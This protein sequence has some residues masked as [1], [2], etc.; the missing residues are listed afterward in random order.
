MH[1]ICSCSTDAT[2]VGLARYGQGAGPIV[3]DDVRCTGSEP[4]ILNC[5]YDVN[6]ADCTHAEDAGVQ[7]SD[8]KFSHQQELLEH[9]SHMHAGRVYPCI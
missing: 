2:A 3:L 1:H 9:T 4:N 5:P 7:C 6:T 8:C